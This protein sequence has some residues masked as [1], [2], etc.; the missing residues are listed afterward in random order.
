MLRQVRWA[1]SVLPCEANRLKKNFFV[2][3][4]LQ[5]FV[6]FRFGEYFPCD[7]ELLQVL[8]QLSLIP[9]LFISKWH[10][11]VSVSYLE[12]SSCET[13][14][15]LFFVSGCYRGLV[16]DLTH[17]AFSFYWAVV[18]FPT[19]T[20]FP[21]VFLWL[22]CFCYLQDGFVVAI[23]YLLAIGHAAVAELYGVSVENFP[24]FVTH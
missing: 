8:T 20:R 19:A 5:R 9:S 2:V 23:Y 7:I 10:W 15:C 21:S 16:H 13:D 22:S 12:L 14:V 6:R 24:Q 18:F 11:M 1:C 3:D 4:W 17:H